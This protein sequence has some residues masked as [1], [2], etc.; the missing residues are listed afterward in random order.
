MDEDTVASAD[1]SLHVTTVGSADLDKAVGL[2]SIATRGLELGDEA[3]PPTTRGEANS[4]ERLRLLKSMTVQ[5][6]VAYRAAG[7][8]AA[9]LLARRRAQDLINLNPGD[10]LAHRAHELLTDL[11]RELLREPQ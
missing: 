9:V 8:L 2:L 3:L 10:E 5:Q 7:S 4:E 11:A 6:R 1:A